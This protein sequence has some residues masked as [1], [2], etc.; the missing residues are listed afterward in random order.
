MVQALRE[1]L[2][3]EPQIHSDKRNRVVFT[4][5]GEASEPRAR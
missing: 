5:A 2:F 1:G 3:V 4:E